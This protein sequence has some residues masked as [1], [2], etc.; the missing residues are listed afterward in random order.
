[1]YSTRTYLNVHVYIYIHVQVQLFWLQQ[2]SLA[3]KQH[4]HIVHVVAVHS[5]DSMRL[6]CVNAV[7]AVHCNY[8]VGQKKYSHGRTNFGPLV[9]GAGYTPAHNPSQAG[10]WDVRELAID[11]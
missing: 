4:V 6:A 7:L 3:E 5:Q 11:C 8:F 10:H 2:V 1:M 9:V